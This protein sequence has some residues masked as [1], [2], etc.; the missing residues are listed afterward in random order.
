MAAEGDG[1][2]LSQ[3]KTRFPRV[4]TLQTTLGVQGH[5]PGVGTEDCQ[6]LVYP[7]AAVACPQRPAHP[8]LQR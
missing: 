2:R 1:V 7:W 6:T 3:D 4:P 8:P 5:R